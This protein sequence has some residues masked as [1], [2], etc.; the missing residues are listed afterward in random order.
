MK[1]QELKDNLI[2]A[3]KQL[4]EYSDNELISVEG[5]VRNIS[6]LEEE[7]DKLD[8]DGTIFVDEDMFNSMDSFCESYM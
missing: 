8:L 3:L 6:E 1:P 2:L 7:L 4:K 5:E